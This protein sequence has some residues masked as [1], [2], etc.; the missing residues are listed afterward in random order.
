MYFFCFAILETSFLSE[1]LAWENRRHFVTL[2]LVSPPNVAEK[3]AQKFQT[4]DLSLP[5]SGQCFLLVE[6]NFPRGTTNQKHYPELGGGTP[7]VWDFGTRFSDVVWRGDQWWRREMSQA[8]LLN[9][10]KSYLFWLFFQFR[11]NL[12]ENN[13]VV[14]HPVTGAQIDFHKLASSSGR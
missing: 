2:Q 12:E 10:N 3:R 1:H 14:K 7:S 6:A 4:D 9:V 5:W 8:D 11:K 13:C